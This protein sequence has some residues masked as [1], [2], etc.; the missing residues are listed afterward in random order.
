[1]FAG[2]VAFLSLIDPLRVVLSHIAR[3][4][5]ATHFGSAEII[6]HS[7]PSL[8]V[9]NTSMYAHVLRCRVIDI[10]TLLER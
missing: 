9:F 7:E 5:S 3:E 1:M 4:C 10:N 2:R 8:H 6:Q